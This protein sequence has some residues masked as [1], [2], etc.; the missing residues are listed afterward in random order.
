MK[1]I[2]QQQR[3]SSIVAALITLALGLILVL[4]PQRTAEFLCMLLGA[5]VFVTGLVYVLGWFVRRRREEA[6]VYLLI[7]GVILLAIGVWMLTSPG[8]IIHL[9]Q[10]VFGALLIFHGVVDLQG[11]VALM[12]RGWPRW[13]LDLALSA[14]TLALGALILMNPFASFDLLVTLTG[15]SLVYDGVSDLV[16]IHRLSRAWREAEQDIIDIE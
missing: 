10:Y 15:L 3:R 12:R 7:P 2:L 4:W 6:P 14:L 8:G 13:W 5:A 16:L 9:I 11:A 1:S